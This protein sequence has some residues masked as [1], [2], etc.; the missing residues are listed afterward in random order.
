M[1]ITPIV[2]GA[3]NWN[4]V[5]IAIF[6]IAQAFT[7][8]MVYL[9]RNETAKLGNETVK[10]GI[11]ASDLVKSTDKLGEHTAANAVNIEKIEIATNSMK[12]ELVKATARASFAEG[13]AG[14]SKAAKADLA[15]KKNVLK[16]AVAKNI[17]QRA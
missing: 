13:K 15:S 3:F 16:K 8:L 1:E 7:A 14:T 2:D 12:D 4:N 17:R 9:N 10:L 11:V 5:F 6:A